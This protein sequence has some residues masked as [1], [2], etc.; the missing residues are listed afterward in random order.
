MRRYPILNLWVDD[1][2]MEKAVAQVCKYID[3]GKRV[4]TVFAS[5]PE[6]NYSVPKN[7]TGLFSKRFFPLTE[8]PK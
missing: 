1:C 2:D 8:S 6:K 4:Y 7:P 5:N 3:M